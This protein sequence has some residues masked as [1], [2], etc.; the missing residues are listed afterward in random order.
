MV[1][2][3]IVRLPMTNSSSAPKRPTVSIR[4]LVIDPT[5]EARRFR[6]ARKDYIAQL[7]AETACLNA[8]ATR[9]NAEAEAL[10]AQNKARR[11]KIAR[12]HP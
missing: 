11:A 10:E 6:A 1:K 7:D 5:R 2:P 4:H 9:I 3:H 12:R 8:E